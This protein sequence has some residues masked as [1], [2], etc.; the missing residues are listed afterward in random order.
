MRRAQDAVRIRRTQRHPAVR[1]DEHVGQAAR[2]PLA[3]L[4]G[5]DDDVE[6]E[7]LG[8]V[9][10]HEHDRVAALLGD[11]RLALPRGE[12]RLLVAEADEPLE[13][14][15][16]HR[17]E[18]GREPRQLAQVGVAA[19]AVGHRQAGQVV[20]VLGHD[21]LAEPLE[22]DLAGTLDQPREPLRERERQPPVGQARGPAPARR[23]RTR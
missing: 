14:G 13:V 12:R 1:R 16:A 10:R 9:H 21:Q 19:V 8:G 15:A 6:L 11:R 23:A 7:P 3:A 17:L 20:V 4:V 22:R 18:L 5:Q 2:R